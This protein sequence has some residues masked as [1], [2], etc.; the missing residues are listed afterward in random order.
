MK[1]RKQNVFLFGLALAVLGILVLSACQPAVVPEPTQDPAIAAL[2]YQLDELQGQIDDQSGDIAQLEA[3]KAALQEQ[4]EEA[5]KT[6]EPTEPPVTE[7]PEVTEEPTPT[8]DPY[9]CGEFLAEGKI[10]KIRDNRNGV[11]QYNDAGNPLPEPLGGGNVQYFANGDRTCVYE[12]WV[13]FDGGRM[14]KLWYNTK[15]V[16]TGEWLSGEN[17]CFVKYATFKPDDAKYTLPIEIE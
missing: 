13:Q 1:T 11:L 2:Q 9:R 3:D 14:F 15:D 10:Y 12:K 17:C 4:L 5:L 16:R 8:K 7:E 6:P